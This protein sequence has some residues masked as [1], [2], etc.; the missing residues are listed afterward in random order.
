MTK[1]LSDGGAI[2]LDARSESEYAEGH[3]KG[4][5]CTPYDTFV[6]DTE[7]L[8][9]I[10][11]EPRPIIVYCSGGD[12]EASLN[13]GWEILDFGHKRVLVFE[14]GY[15]AWVDAGYPTASGMQP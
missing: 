10:A 2:I 14:E 9:K 6:D 5:R 1:K 7:W 8:E 12:C 11:K 4:A 3:I 13:L 15:P